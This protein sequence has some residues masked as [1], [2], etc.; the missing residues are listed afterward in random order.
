MSELRELL[1]E[2]GVEELPSGYIEPALASMAARSAARLNELGL[3]FTGMETFGSPRRLTLVIR[4]LQDQQPDRK[5]EYIGP[6]KAAGLDANGHLTRAAA[7]FARSHGLD[8]EALEIV[9]TPKG[10]YFM[11]VE[12]IRGEATKTLLPGLLES[13]VRETVFPKSMRWASTT[14]TFARPIQW[15][16]ALY[17]GE[18]VPLAIEQIPCGNLSYGHRFHA[19][20]AFAVTGVDDYLQALPQRFVLPL[21]GRRREM[22][23]AGVKKAVAE[24]VPVADA[25]A[26]LHEGLLA[27]VSNLVEYP[28]PICGH[29][30]EKFLQVPAE[31]IITSMRENQK[32]FP[33]KDG[34]GALLPYFVAVNNT[35]IEDRS[36]AVSGHERVLRARLED[37]L[38]FFN[39]D[40]K[41]KMESHCQRLDGIVFHQKLGTMQA[42]S[43]RIVALAGFLADRLAPE[44]S[45]TV[46]RAAH[47]AKADLLTS[48]VGEFP[49]LQG[50]MG[51][52]YALHDGESPAVAQAIE[53]HYLPLHA[54]GA[55]PASLAG[56][57]VSLADRMDTLVG[58]FAVGEKP[59]G[60]KDALGLRRQALGLVS[61][62][63][64]QHL[65]LSLRA[66]AEKAL[67]LYSGV[68]AVQK[69]GEK[70][71]DDVLAFIRLRFENEQIA[72]G[73]PQEV[74][75][76]ATAPRFDDICD[77]M[78]R[79]EALLAF[80]GEENFRILTA[81]FKRIRNIVKDN[82][83][84]EIRP[85]CFVEEA[86]KALF[87][88]LG[89]AQEASRPLLERARYHEAL[90][91]MLLIKEPLDR[92][93][94][95]VMVMA[96]DPAQR[97]NRL[98]LLT[99]L[100]AMM[101]E[102][103]DISRMSVKEEQKP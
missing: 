69:A 11:A 87:A 53:E 73:R 96:S 7:G 77:C 21:P 49:E 38:F 43:A 55:A 92:F 64:R 74:V 35:C 88:A 16:L 103:A 6:S 27:T 31:A 75:E 81:S 79:I 4:A 13:L 102:V 41:A 52:V 14:L 86:E 54:G 58:C 25:Q 28:Y 97:Q 23:V 9:D 68:A 94:D 91:A 37:A 48:M 2:I 17:G 10:P 101:L 19:P 34:K 66:L 65:A 8:P 62:I 36:L 18:I 71:V 85:E 63:R 67:A 70:T 47:L 50:V 1:F 20:Q 99:A 29:F 95:Q 57:I 98:N 89:Q 61:V 80:R 93:F 39:E 72:E 44:L 83:N 60:N 56:A 12:D 30:D 46:R 90:T 33:V 22:V 26:E 84:T 40:R 59:T 24:Q 32:Y 78:H 5:R 82:R 15:F 42:K 45:D 76:A 51:R 100:L 3:S